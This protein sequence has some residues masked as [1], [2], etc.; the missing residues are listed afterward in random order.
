MEREGGREGDGEGRGV[1]ISVKIGSA[2]RMGA[3]QLWISG[4]SSSAPQ[5]LPDAHLPTH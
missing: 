5:H 4:A 2:T 3:R 1:D